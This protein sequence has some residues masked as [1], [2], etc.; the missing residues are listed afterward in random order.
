LLAGAPV[1]ALLLGRFI[2]GLHPFVLDVRPHLVGRGRAALAVERFQDPMERAAE[3]V[4][5]S[6]AQKEP[7]DLV[8]V[9]VAVLH[10]AFEIR[11][12]PGG[13]ESGFTRLCRLAR[14]A[15]RAHSD[16]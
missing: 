10:R 9:D 12:D 8:D 5:G 6:R 15:R 7:P 11:T 16:E 14:F 1:L 4:S 3:T 13:T 2:A